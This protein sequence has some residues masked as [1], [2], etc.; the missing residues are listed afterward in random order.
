MAD[1]EQCESCGVPKLIKG[2]FSWEDSGIISIS[3]SPGARM[4]FYES[5][6]I[7]NI[8]RGMEELIGIPIEH[9]VTERKRRDTRRFM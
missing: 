4:V 7:D 5:G 9:I 3:Y 2:V 1:I 8:F 6:N